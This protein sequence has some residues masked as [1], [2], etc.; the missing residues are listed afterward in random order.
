MNLP[1]SHRAAPFH[2]HYFVRSSLLSIAM[3]LLASVSVYAQDAV[4]PSL[5]GQ[6]AYNA[7]QEDV[8][9]IPYNLL[10][11]PVRLRVGA[12]VGVEYND[13]IN[14]ADDGSGVIPNPSGPGFITVTA[15]PQEDVIVTPNLTLDMIWP[16]T[17]L[18]T[19]RV[20]LGIGY[21]FYL[22]HSNDNTDYLLVAPKSQVAFDIFVGD[23]RINLHDRMQLQQDPIQEGALSN[24][25]D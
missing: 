22:D 16:V 17:Q 20:D 1:M 19:L 2:R 3:T 13:N 21:S 14:Y 5:A 7:R 8:S 24:V 9:R 10:V 18:N 23:F 12:T 6:D 15:H 4:R 11:G 25:V